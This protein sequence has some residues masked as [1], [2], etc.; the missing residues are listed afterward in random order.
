MALEGNMSF[1]SHKWSIK[2]I[3]DAI[4]IVEVEIRVIIEDQ[5]FYT[6]DSADDKHDRDIILKKSLH[7]LNDLKKNH[8]VVLEPT[9]IS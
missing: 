8:A 5:K 3:N 6:G 4:S 2:S 9:L 7:A 1:C